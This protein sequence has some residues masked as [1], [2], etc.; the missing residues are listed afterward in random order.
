MQERDGDRRP[1]RLTF[2]EVDTIVDDVSRALGKRRASEKK[3]G[4]LLH[5][6]NEVLAQYA[7]DVRHEKLP[8][9]N[10]FEKNWYEL[11]NQLKRLKR[12]LPS[13]RGGDRDLQLFEA[14]CRHGEAYAEKHGPHRGLEPIQLPAL[15]LP[16]LDQPELNYRS[17]ALLR[18]LIDRIE[19]VD[20]W[21]AAYNKDLVPRM[22]WKR[23]EAHWKKEAVRGRGR[24]I[25]LRK[26]RVRLIGDA[27]PKLYEEYFGKLPRS[28]SSS[29]KNRDGRIYRPWVIFVCAIHKA[30]FDRDIPPATVEEYWKRMQKAG[31]KTEVPNQTKLATVDLEYICSQ[32][33]SPCP[34]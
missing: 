5:S 11:R 31:L 9:Q 30:A 18:E 13:P 4:R 19:Q 34:P 27:L 25:A 20:K 23:L 14:I 6:V 29:G 24:D 2:R 33:F 26:A 7:T 1:P 21:M 15:S 17:S 28:A 12:T 8:S 32:N 22:G 16:G 10:E 3:K